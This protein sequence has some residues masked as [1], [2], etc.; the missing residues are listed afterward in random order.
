MLGYIMNVFRHLAS[1]SDD[2]LNSFSFGESC[3]AR[4]LYG[5]D[6][7]A[8]TLWAYNKIALLCRFV[9]TDL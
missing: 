5:N 9:S 1:T 8:L 7:E 2:F 3:S 6:W 4:M